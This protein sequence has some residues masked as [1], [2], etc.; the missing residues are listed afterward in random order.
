MSEGKLLKVEI[1]CA[2]IAIPSLIVPLLGVPV[3]LACFA[4]S[5]FVQDFSWVWGLKFGGLSVISL[6]IG[7]FLAALCK[8]IRQTIES[9]GTKGVE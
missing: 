1:L 5:L 6:L 9:M 2:A 4:V 8:A 3:T 7:I